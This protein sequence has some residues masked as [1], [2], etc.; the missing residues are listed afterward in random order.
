[1]KSLLENTKKIGKYLKY[2][3]GKLDLSLSDLS[4]KTGLT[5][6]YLSRLERGEYRSMSL[7]TLHRLADALG[8]SLVELLTKGQVLQNTNSLPSLTY[9]LKERYQLPP[10]AIGDVR[11]FL[12]FVTKKYAKEIRLMQKQHSQYWKKPNSK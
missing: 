2:Q 10:S 7:K 8:M 11:L 12:E 9:Y 6:A 3:R 5:S 1:M 4:E